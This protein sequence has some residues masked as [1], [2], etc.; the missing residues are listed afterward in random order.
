MQ[1][2]P[3]TDRKGRPM[4]LAHAAHR[5]SVRASVIVVAAIAAIAGLLI[6]AGP[7]A[8]V[9]TGSA[10]ARSAPSGAAPTAQHA[11]P[12]NPSPPAGFIERKVKVNGIG[13]NYV[14]G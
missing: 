9:Q 6:T 13:I 12:L 5:T 4:K 8:S 11:C 1:S 2:A 3:G 14:R 7:G 10:H